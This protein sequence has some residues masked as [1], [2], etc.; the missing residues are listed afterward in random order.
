MAPAKVAHTIA[1]VHDAFLSWKQ[2]SMAERV[3]RMHQAAKLLRDQASA[4]ALRMAQE[5]GNR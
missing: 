5:M 4:Y 3:Q 1:Q 2:T